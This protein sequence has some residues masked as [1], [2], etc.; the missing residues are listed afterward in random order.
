MMQTRQLIFKPI[1]LDMH[2]SVCIAFRRDSYLC[3]FGEDGFFNEAGSDGVHYI[4]WLW[5]RINKFPDGCVHA[6]HGDKIVGQMEMQIL[7][8]PRRGYVN[9]FYLV[10][11]MRGAGVSRELQDYAMEFMRQHRVQLAQLSV[12]PTNARALAFYRKHGWRDL[13]LRPGRDN[14]NLMECDVPYSVRSRL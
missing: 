1:D 11:E 12:S 7:E 4:E 13:G 14:V 3:S 6:W 9:L 2:A 10:E 8:E 5:L